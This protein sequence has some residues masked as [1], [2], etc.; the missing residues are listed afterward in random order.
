[1]KCFASGSA[2]FPYVHRRHYGICLV[3]MN[4]DRITRLMSND[5]KTRCSF[6]FLSLLFEFKLHAIRGAFLLS[7]CKERIIEPNRERRWHASLLPSFSALFSAHLKGLQVKYIAHLIAFLFFFSSHQL[8]VWSTLGKEHPKRR[9]FS[10]S[11]RSRCSCYC[12]A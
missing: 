3:M 2:E 7:F 5:A 1:M 12:A 9:I 4:L 8:D 10:C 6:F 11:G